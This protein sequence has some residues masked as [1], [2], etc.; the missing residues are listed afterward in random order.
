M[1]QNPKRKAVRLCADCSTDRAKVWREWR[2]VWL[3]DQ[4]WPRRFE[5]KR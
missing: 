5:P 1:R 3:C 2:T 4:C